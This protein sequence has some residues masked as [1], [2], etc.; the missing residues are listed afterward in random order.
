M[1]ETAVP[2]IRPAIGDSTISSAEI[3]NSQTERQNG[4]VKV[5][6]HYS[7]PQHGTVPH[8]FLSVHTEAHQRTLWRSI[9]G[10]DCA[11]YSSLARVYLCVCLFITQSWLMKKL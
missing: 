6:S 8:V 10:C 11:G 2:I 3:R 7:T 9:S 1:G 4:T 5:R